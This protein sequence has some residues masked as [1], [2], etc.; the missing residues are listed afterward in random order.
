MTM[1]IIA[2]TELSS[3]QS[4]ISFTNIDQTGTDLYLFYS[5]RTTGTAIDP[6]AF[7]FNTDTGANYSMRMLYGGGSSTGSASNSSY[8]SQYNAWAIFWMQASNTTSST[9]NN[10]SVYLPNYSLSNQYKSLLVDAVTENNAT[11]ANQQIGTGIWNS[12]NAI[13]AITLTAYNSNFVVG[14]SATLYKITKGTDSITT[15][16]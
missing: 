12:N 1:T 14:S 8:L 7:Y 5:V 2:H 16:S 13:N 6:S 3:E 11:A 10:V 15:V 9:F 4:S